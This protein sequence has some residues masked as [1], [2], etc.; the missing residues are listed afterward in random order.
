[1]DLE[2]VRAFRSVV[3]E[4]GFS[5]AARVLHLTQPS[6]SAR[7]RRLEEAVGEVLLERRGRRLRLTPAGRHLID[8]ADALIRAAEDFRTAALDFRGLRRGTLDIGT[9]DLASIYVL[10]R[11]FRRFVRGHPGIDLSV[12]VDGSAPLMDALR[13]GR[14]ELAVA[15]LPVEE[16]DV[17]GPE[18]ERDRLLP[19]LPRRH[20]LAERRRMRIEELADTPMLTFKS[21]SVTRRVVDRAFADKGVRPSVAMEISSPEAIKKLVEVGLGFAVLPERSVRAEIRAGRLA[22]PPLVGVRLERRVGLLQI[23]DRYLSPAAE[24]FAD[25]V[26]G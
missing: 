17:D 12:T 6:V 15:N 13:S 16:D 23:R 3:R 1:M 24:A 18:I 2:N 14:I 8:R 26:T 19:I 25:A 21:N 20:R 10:P 5:A 7:I 22:S 11:A 9:T 4:G